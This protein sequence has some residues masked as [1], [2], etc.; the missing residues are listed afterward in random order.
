MKNKEL[1]PCPFCG[2]IPQIK[3]T[4][5]YTIIICQNEN[6]FS[7]PNAS[8]FTEKDALNKWNTRLESSGLS[9]EE[10][11]K[12]IRSVYVAGGEGDYELGRVAGFDIG[13][14]EAL[15][16]QVLADH[17]VF[18][19]D[20]NGG[21]TAFFKEIPNVI[22]EAET[23]DKAIDN[24]IKALHDIVLS[25]SSAWIPV[26]KIEAPGT[27]KIGRDFDE[28]NLCSGESGCYKCDDYLP[29]SPIQKG[30]QE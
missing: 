9:E 20:K 6:C 25:K 17:I 13:Y 11:K 14:R 21:F 16:R 12:R 28:C 24:L 5:G 3:I 19:E 26:S 4:T 27:C 18:V 22:T 8:A 15:S 1:K 23:K 10:V 7:M 30:D 29:S 2:E